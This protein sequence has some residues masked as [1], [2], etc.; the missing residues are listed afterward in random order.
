LVCVGTVAWRARLKAGLQ[1]L[2]LAWLAL[3]LVQASLGAWTIWSN[4]AAD[5][6]T[7][8]MALGALTLFVSARLAFRLFVMQAG[9]RE[10]SL[11][12]SSGARYSGLSA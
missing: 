5:I 12:F 1:R 7:A 10:E 4:K 6:A 9:V 11:E 3:I 8:H 2:A